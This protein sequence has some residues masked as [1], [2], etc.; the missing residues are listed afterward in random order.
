M[1]PTTINWVC[2]IDISEDELKK[3]DNVLDI[4]LTDRTTQSNIIWA[5]DDYQHLGKGFSFFDSIQVD[6]ITGKY[7]TI[8]QP[9]I[10]KH[11][12]QQRKRSKQ[13]AEVFT[14][15]WVC[16]R[17]NNLIDEAWFGTQGV[18]NHETDEHT[19]VSNP[20][21][22]FPENKSLDQYITLKRIEIT[23]GEAPYLV[24]RYDAT[25]G[26]PIAIGNRIGML[27]RK[28][29]AIHTLTPNDSTALPQEERD[30]LQAEWQNK[31]VRAYQS[32][33]GF[34]WQGDN[35]LLAREALFVS[36]IE[37]YQAK[38][39]TT[40]LPSIEVM[41][42]I[43]TIISWNIWQMDGLSCG[44]PGYMPM[45]DTN[46]NDLFGTMVIPPQKHYC[47][48]MDWNSTEPLKGTELR[49]KTMLT[50]KNT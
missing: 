38:W 8:I 18:F 32:I 1:K 22:Q 16:N 17:Q 40:T 6:L 25:T 24:S 28:L 36:F 12:L 15:A 29:W 19:W 46:N 4:L 30:T 34:E 48:I 39:H 31:V 20:V 35:L 11:N 3:L 21:P 23:C 44:I 13:M 27:D 9:R 10:K 5:S 43:A 26:Q 47:R 49:F 2:D 45:E 42:K 7:S 50:T 14:P 33:Y 41:Q 37:Y